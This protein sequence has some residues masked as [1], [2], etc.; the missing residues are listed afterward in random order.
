MIIKEIRALH[1]QVKHDY[2]AGLYQKQ[3]TFYA[4]NYAKNTS[5]DYQLGYE[6][7]VRDN[8]K[9][10]QKHYPRRLILGLNWV[11][12]NQLHELVDFVNGYND[13]YRKLDK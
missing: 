8:H 9:Q 5:S 1:D 6:Q 3:T 12:F 7:A 10:Q 4:K 11:L 13:F 2:E